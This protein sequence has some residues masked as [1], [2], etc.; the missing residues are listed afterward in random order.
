MFQRARSNKRLSLPLPGLPMAAYVEFRV[1]AVCVSFPSGVLKQ[2]A[3]SR[4]G[5]VT[6]TLVANLILLAIHQTIAK[7]LGFPSADVF[8]AALAKL[9]S[10]LGPPLKGDSSGTNTPP[11]SRS[12]KPGK[13]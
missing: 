4:P 9:A 3:A 1:V 7:S 11:K 10:S 5:L 6:A 12:K 13:K 8:S 2:F